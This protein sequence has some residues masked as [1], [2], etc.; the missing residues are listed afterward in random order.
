[1]KEFL[2]RLEKETAQAWARVHS[3]PFWRHLLDKGLDQDLYVGLMTEIFHYT[4]YNAQNQALAALRV[5]SDRLPLL[6][7]CLNHALEEAGHDLMVLND[8]ESIGIAPAVIKGKTPL[9]ET[10]AFIAYLFHVASELDATARLGY[11][12]WA[13]NAYGYVDDLLKAMRRDLGLGD[14]Q[15]TF[16]VAHASIDAEHFDD[17]R[18]I[19]D[20]ACTQPEL[21]DDVVSV[22]RTSLHLTGNIM[23]AAYADYMARRT[24]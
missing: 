16:F 13:E 23:D 21:Q 10:Q 2:D 18:K 12:F 5:T 8:L 11:S 1:M 3:G 9:P 4:R 14:R 24:R 7:Y 15:M 17:V 19:L 20:R 22:L 6:R